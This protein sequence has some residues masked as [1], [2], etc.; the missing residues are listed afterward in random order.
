MAAH[1]QKTGNRAAVYSE[2]GTLEIEIKD[3]PI[4]NPGP[5]EVLIRLF[6]PR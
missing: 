3:L 6:V 1:P 4:P 2:P 5:G